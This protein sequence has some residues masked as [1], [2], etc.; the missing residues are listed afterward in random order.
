MNVEKSNG[1]CVAVRLP[2][3]FFTAVKQASQVAEVAIAA[4]HS[5]SEH[6]GLN[7]GKNMG[8]I[9]LK[10]H[11]HARTPTQFVFKTRAEIGLT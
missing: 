11:Y 1:L 7:R 6:K 5:V 2:C 10:G 4:P 3:L 9:G 8:Q